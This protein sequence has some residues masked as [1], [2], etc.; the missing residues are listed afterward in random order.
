MTKDEFL[1]VNVGGCEISIPVIGDVCPR[2]GVNL[3][4]VE[5]SFGEGSKSRYISVKV[6]PR[7]VIDESVRNMCGVSLELKD[8]HYFKGVFSSVNMCSIAREG[9]VNV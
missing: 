2:C 9:S 5:E 3:K 8:W 1:M 6:C 7:C 4:A